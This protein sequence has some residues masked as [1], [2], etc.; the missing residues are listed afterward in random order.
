MV[1]KKLMRQ[2]CNEPVRF[3]VD[4][5]QLGGAGFE[6]QMIKMDDVFLALEHT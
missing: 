2:Q 3:A 1:R 6:C 5:S 4:E